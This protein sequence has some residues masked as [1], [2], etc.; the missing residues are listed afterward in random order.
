VSLA[1]RRWA[2]LAEE[3]EFRQ[4]D[5]VR[6][7]AETWRSGLTGAT[8]LLGAV[9]VV[10]GPESV[11]SLPIPLRVAVLVLLAG[12]LGVFVAATYLVV[13]ASAGVPDAEIRLTGPALKAWTRQ[14]VQAVRRAVR[15]AMK[16]VVT[17]VAL[18]L[19]AVALT[20][21]TPAPAAPQTVVVL[22]QQA[23]ICGTLTGIQGSQLTL[24]V[25]PGSP[26]RPL[27]IP[28]ADVRSLAPVAC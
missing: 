6:K 3:A 14:E 28:L 9:L 5:G 8:G 15:W 25:D 17:G 12:A 27:Q 1:D 22:T 21:L 18:L 7:S 26:V 24:D 11:S 13:R 10:K 16:G 2:L 4:L 23:R 20:W 19:V